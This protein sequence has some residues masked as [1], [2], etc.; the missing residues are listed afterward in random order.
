[1]TFVDRP[2]PETLELTPLREPKPRDERWKNL[3]RDGRTRGATNKITRDLKEGITTAAENIGRDGNG[4]GGLV[5]YLEDLALYHKR[6][7]ASLL[8]KV[9]PMQVT[10]D[11]GHHIS[12]VRI[13]SIPSG[14]YLSADGIEK[15]RVPGRSSDCERIAPPEGAVVE[16]AS[17]PEF[18]PQTETERQLLAKLEALSPEQLQELATRVGVDVAGE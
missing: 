14:S 2:L 18:V 10:G 1:M 6:A 11:V 16:S 3:T 9:L 8:V 13:V 12:S 7:F 4:E 15:Y 5:G 17:E